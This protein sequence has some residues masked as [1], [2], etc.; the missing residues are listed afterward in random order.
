MSIETLDISGLYTLSSWLSSTSGNFTVELKGVKVASVARLEIGQNGKLQ[1]QDIDMDLTFQK[2]NIDFENLGLLG[3]F[4]KS[5]IN[6][7]GILIFDTVK[8]FVLNQLINTHI[9]YALS[10]KYQFG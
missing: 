1:T 3:S 4:F 7:V 6:S 9:R 2:M 5:V 8:F 10:A